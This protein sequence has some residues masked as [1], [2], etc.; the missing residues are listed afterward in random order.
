MG[1][2]TTQDILEVLVEERNRGNSVLGGMLGDG[3]IQ[4]DERDPVDPT[5]FKNSLMASR[6]IYIGDKRVT[7]NNVY[8]LYLPSDDNNLPED[9]DF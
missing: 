3:I 6:G 4:C 8:D 2:T 9:Y 1:E 5:H 7:N